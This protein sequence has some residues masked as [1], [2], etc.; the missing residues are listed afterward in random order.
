[1]PTTRNKSKTSNISVVSSHA[2][3]RTRRSRLNSKDASTGPLKQVYRSPPADL[4]LRVDC[5]PEGFSPSRLNLKVESK[6]QS[7][8]MGKAYSR[9]YEYMN[10]LQSI[11]G[12]PVKSDIMNCHNDSVFV[13]PHDPS[14]NGQIAHK[15]SNYLQVKVKEAIA[16]IQKI[17]LTCLS[18]VK[19]KSQRGRKA[20]QLPKP[21]GRR[22][23]KF[24]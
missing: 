6:D 17:E 14:S 21:R 10:G 8:R 2:P 22:P 13:K 3:Q 18:P 9:Q 20:S 11:S 12:N 23:N 15:S 1:M 24:K 5:T 7:Q 4:K 19:K 16:D